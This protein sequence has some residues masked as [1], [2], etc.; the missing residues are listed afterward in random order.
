MMKINDDEYA[1]ALKIIHDYRAERGLDFFFP[2][3]I[4]PQDQSITMDQFIL[5]MSI[6][7]QLSHNLNPKDNA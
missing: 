3:N 1:Q 4:Q 2:I 7:K 5:F 6:Q